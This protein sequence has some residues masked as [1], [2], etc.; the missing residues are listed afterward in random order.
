MDDIANC[1][2][3]PDGVYYAVYTGL[4]D[5]KETSLK[6]IDISLRFIARELQE[7]AYAVPR[8]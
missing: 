3:K 7:I 2:I 6:N 4:I 5:D 1:T 8:S